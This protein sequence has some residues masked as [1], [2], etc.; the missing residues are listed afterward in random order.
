MEQ[1]KNELEERIAFSQTICYAQNTMDRKF[2]KNKIEDLRSEIQRLDR[3]RENVKGQLSA[4]EEIFQKDEKAQNGSAR[5][6]PAVVERQGRGLS[7]EWK[8]VLRL[9]S[10]HDRFDYGSVARTAKTAGLDV[11]LQTIRGRIS[12]YVNDGYVERIREGE[13]KITKKGKEIAS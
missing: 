1:N 2:I 10:Y 8:M 9:L 6:R 4:Y 5:G 11:E 7:S 3:Q 13:F 12:K